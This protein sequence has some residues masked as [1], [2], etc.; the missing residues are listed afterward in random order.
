MFIISKKVI[1]VMEVEDKGEDEEEGGDDRGWKGDRIQV[2]C[3]TGN[4]A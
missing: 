2:H 1:K 4:W 3:K